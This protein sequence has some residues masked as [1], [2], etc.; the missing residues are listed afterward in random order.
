ML[1][2]YIIKL[3][4]QYTSTNN[5]ISKLIKNEQTV[6]NNNY[7]YD[8]FYHVYGIEFTNININDKIDNIIIKIKR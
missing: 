4:L 8:S 5:K 3:Q 7:K 1:S 6:F 2:F